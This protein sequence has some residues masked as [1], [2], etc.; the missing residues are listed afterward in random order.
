MN[1]ILLATVFL[2][3]A[4]F[5]MACNKENGI[6]EE[7]EVPAI[8]Q[9]ID[10]I[11]I[12]WDYSSMVKI[13]PAD[14][15]TIAYCGYSRLI[16]LRNNRLACVYETS[17]GNVELVFS[18]DL[19]LTWSVPQIIFAKENN[20]NMAV[21]DL[22]EL[23]DH[24]LLIACN[25]RPLEPYSDDRKFGIKVRKSTDG[26]EN[27]LDEQ[28]LYEAQSTFN[29]GCWEPSFAQLPD[30]EV[31]LFFSNEGIYTSSDEQNI[32]VLRSTD[33]GN[34][35]TE[36]PE[37]IGFRQGRRD[38]M[39][40]PLVLEDKGEII[41][42]IED[43]KVGQFKPGIYHEKITDNWT[44]G[45]VSADD[46]RRDY[47]PLEDPFEEAVYA[48]GPY[49]A[50]LKTGDVLL[51]YQSTWNR[52]DLWDRSC[53]HIEIGDDSGRQFKNRSVPFK[54][55]LSK[56]GLWNS[57]SVIEDGSVPVALTSTN[58]Y[59]YSSTEVWMIKG[60]VI[61]EFE[62]QSGTAT[63]D[64]VLDEECWQNDWPYFIGHESNTHLSASLCIDE[65]SLYVG[66]KG[67]DLPAE[68]NSTGK[69]TFHIDTDRTGY[70]K[71]HEGTYSF[72]CGLD[73]QL[74]IK[75][76]SYGGWEEENVPEKAQYLVKNDGSESQLELAIPLELFN[77]VLTG[78]IGV[79][80]VLSYQATTGRVD[81]ALA[82]CQEN[83][84]YTWCPASIK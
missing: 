3:C 29:N 38:G 20:I 59:S 31:Q 27:W 25:P 17:A 55:P 40:T 53:Q 5:L 43:N 70:E 52:S 58:A 71:P 47:H 16:Q 79:N 72:E 36:E 44:D 9:N 56:W 37:I 82:N 12:A 64:G 84:P 11:R 66:M 68:Y 80:F 83:S 15:R 14:G 69:V 41:V 26:G 67:N 4:V 34:N 57:V 75:Q 63:V 13:A 50:R 24:S 21:P 49:L 77:N 65:G 60:H 46:N 33:N 78:E 32:S 8:K 74:V 23:S 22:I 6:T 18:D 54:I 2:Y 61:P 30:G 1:R 81:E 42:A 62:I 73:G 39:P 28:L 45:Y 10:G 76:G 48:G 7:R 19:G 51:S 35:W